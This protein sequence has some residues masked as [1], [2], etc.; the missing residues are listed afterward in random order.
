MSVPRRFNRP[1]G[2][3][4]ID[5]LIEDDA[6]ISLYFN[7]VEV[8]EVI[9][10][11]K[12]SFL[13][14]G[15][16][17]LKPQTEIKFE[18]TN[19]NTGAVIY[20][21]PVP[22][23]LEGTSRRVSIEVYEDADLFGDATLTVVGELDPSQTDVPV[24]FQGV[25]NVRYT[26]KIYV[27][28]AG[29]NTQPI[30]FYNQPRMVVGEI[31]KP[32]I[33]TTTPSG[34]AQQTGN[35]TGEPTPE[36][37]GKTTNTKEIEE[38]GSFLKTEKNKFST[39]LFGGGGNNSFVRKGR[40]RARRS[41]PETDK[42]TITKKDG[43]DFDAKLIGGELTIKNPQVDTSKFELQDFHEVP[44]TFKADI[45]NVKNTGTLVPSKPFTIIDTRFDED[46]PER[47]VIV[48]LAESGFE[49]TASFSPLPTQSI[50]TVNFRSYADIRLSKL[51]TFSGDIDRV[52]VYA[53]NKD[54]F[55]DFEVVS[56]Q[57]I[58]S[59]ELLFNVFGA[60]NQRI[61]YFFNQDH[62][63]LYWTSG[64]NTS[65]TQDSEYILN[66]VEV[67]GSNIGIDERLLFQQT[68]SL[69][70]NYLKDVD[71]EITANVLG[72]TGPKTNIDNSISDQGLAAIFISG[73]GFEVNHDYGDSL[74]F[75][76]TNINNQPGFLRVTDGSIQDFGLINESFSPV[77][78]GTGIIQFVVFSGRFYIS[79]V[80]I[81]PATDT[82]FSPNFIQ[83]IAPVPPLTQ[84]RPDD[85]EFLAEFY[86]VN[87]NIAETIAFASASTFEGGNSYIL[88][89]DNVLSGSMFIGSSIGGGIEMAGVSSGFIRSIGY[90]GF[91]SASAYPSQGPGFL[92]FSGSV[93]SS[94]T[95]DYT[96]GGVGLELVGHSGSYFRFRTEPAEL[97][98]RTDAFFIGNENIQFI[99]GS[100][101]N[102]EISSS[103]FHLDPK[104]DLLKIGADAIIDADLSVNNI[105]S[106]AGSNI[107]T[108]LAA[109]TSDGFAKFVSASIGAF[110]LNNDSLFSGPNDRPNFFIS[111]SASGTDYFISSSNFQVRAT[112]EVSASSLQLDGGSV[113]G[114]DV[115]DDTVSVGDI[116]KLKD[117]GEITG[118]AVLL[119][120][121]SLSQYLQFIDNT[122]T[123]RG[124]ITVDQ[125]LTPATIAGSP[126]TVLN[127]SSSITADGL[128][129]FKSGSIAGWKIFG[130]KLSGSNATLDADGAAL[131]KSDQGPGTDSGAAF[132][133]LRDEY[134]IDFTPEGGGSSGY[135]IKMGPN[136]GVDKDGILFA[137]GAT[138][139]GSISASAGLIGGFTIGSSSLFSSDLFISGSPL[140]GGV[141]DPRYMFISTSKFNVKQNGD[142]T[143]SN[144]KFSGGEIAGWTINETN[145]TSPDTGIRLNANGD[146][147]EISINS[148]TFANEGIQLGY[149]GGNPRFYA[150]DGAQNFLRYDTSNGVSIKTLKFELDTTALELSSTHASMSLGT[151]GEVLIRG[152]SNS[153]FI[154]LQ[155]S[156]ALVD[157]SYGE[158]GVF[159]GVA[160]GST[161]L[162][163][164]VGTGGH[165]KFNGSSID[166]STDTAV[167]SGSNIQIVS[168]TFLL[169]SISDGNFI[170]GSNGNM[171]IESNNF[172]LSASNIDISSTHASMSVGTTND[173]GHAIKLDGAQGKILVG[174]QSNK[175]I[176]ILGNHAK[177][178]IATGKSSV[179]DTTE[180]FWFANNNAN[181]EFHVGDSNNFIKMQ[182]ALLE[183]TTTNFKLDTST[184]DVDT[185]GGGSIALGT[186]PNTS[187]AGTNKGIFMSGSGDFLLFGN[188]SN[189]F[190]F[191]ST[192][193]SIELKTDTFDLDASTL[194]MKSDSTGSIALGASPP[195]AFDSG[196]GFFVD[197]GGNLLV[198][199]SSGN[200]VQY[201]ATSGTIT[202]K[203][204]TFFLDASTIVIDSSVNSGKIALGPTPPTAYN[205]GNGFYVDGTGKLLIGSGSGN[206]VQF[207]G[208]NIDIVAEAF[209]IGNSNAQFISGSNN[210]IE[211]S[212]SLFHLDPANDALIIGADA[213]INADLTV[214]NLRT[215][216][217][218]GGTA[219]TTLNASSSITS[220]GFA[221]FVSAS[222]GGFDVDDSTITSTDDSLILR[223]SGQISGSAVLL[224]DKS[225]GQ[226]LQFVDSTLTVQ[227]D[228]TANNI[229]TPSSIGGVASTDLNA[230]SSI[231]SQGFA[232]F[233]SAS[234]GGF[235][236]DSSQINSSNDNLVLKSN[237]QITGSDVLFNGG[238]VGGWTITA[239]QLEANNI[240]INAASGYIE[241]GDLNNV[242]DIGDSS[243]GFFANKDGEVLIK[244]GTSA[245]KNYMQFKN[246]TLD[247][248]TDTANISGSS[249]TLETPKFF[250]GKQNFQFVSG[251]NGN[252]EISSSNFHLDNT[253][254]VIMSGNITATTGEIGGFT[255]DSDEIKSAANI[256]LNSSTK[257]LTINDATFGNQGI[258][259][260][261][262]SGTPRMY[263]GDGSSEFFKFDGTNID[264][265][266][267]K[268]T[269]SGSEITL[270]SPDFFLGDTNNFISGSGG[271]LKIFSTGDTTLSGSSV[272]LATPK[273]FMGATGSAYVSGSDGNI[274]ISSSKFFLKSDGTLN[275]GAGNLTTTTDGDVTMT[276]T[277]TANAGTIG[278]FTIDADEIKSGTNI[279]LNSA[280]KALT[281]NDATFGNQGIQL[282]YNSGTP[283]FYVGDGSNRHVK[284]D[285]T[286]VDIKT[287]TFLLDTT[288][289][290]IDSSTARIEVSDGS[291]TRVRI[292]EVDSTS[293][294]HFGL[295]IFDGT[296]TAAS[297]EI[298]HLSD[299]KNQIASWSLS[300]NQI[301][302]QNLVIDSAG[303]I[304]TSDFASG[305]QG[306]RITSANNGEAEFEKVT[307]RGT[308]ATTVFEKETVNAVGGQL[309]VANSTIISQSAQL[310]A[311][312]TTMS[313]AN[314][315]GFV[316]D[317]IISAKK[318]SDTGFSTEYMLIESA[319]RD[320]PSSDKNFAGKLFVVRGYSGSSPQDS[321]SLGD[322]AG[323]ATTY[324]NGQ[325]IV[326]T[327]KIGTGFIRLN[328]NPNDQTTP[329]IDIV[330]RTGSAIYDVS[331][332]ARLGD[333]SGLS[334]GL[335]YGE[336][337]PGFGLF[338]ENVFLSGAITAQT[339]SIEGILH[340]RTDLNNQIKIGTN[341]E[342]SLDGIYIND[343]NF[344]YT[345]GH[346][347]TGFD[348][349]NFIHQSGSKLEIKS[350]DI[351]F[352][353]SNFLLEADG[354]SGQFYLGTITSDSDTSG[355]GVF[356][357]SGGHF[358]VIGNA[359]NQLIVDGGS[360][361]MKS[362]TFDL[363]TSTIHI[364]SSQGGAIAMG[365][366]IPTQLDD[367][368]IFL[369]GSG[370]FNLQGDS[371]NFLRRD[372]NVLT[373][374]AEVFDLDSSTLVMNSAANSGKIA[375]GSTPPTSVAYTANA[376]F[377]VD[378]T[379][380]FLVRADASN[381]IKVYSNTLQL[382][383]ET[384]D[385]DAGTLIIDSAAN[386]GT[387]SLGSTPN[388]SVAGTNTGFYVDGGGDVLLRADADNFIKMNIGSSPVLDMKA[389]TFF[390]GGSAQF[391]S[392]SNGK[393]EVS[394]SNFHLQPDGDTIMQGKITATSGQI[395]GLNIASD[396]IFVGT[397]N[398]NNSDTAFYV[399]DDG[400]FSLKDKLSWD[401]S[402]LSIEGSIT[403]TGG[404]GFASPDAVSGSFAT[405]EAV[406]GSV[407]TLSGSVATD[408]GG[409][410]QGSQ[411]MAT[412][413]VLDSAGMTLKNQSG[414]TLAEYGTTI[415]LRGNGSTDDRLDIDS[416]GIDIFEGGQLRAI[417]GQ[418]T[419]L[420]SGGAAVTTTSTDDC[421]RIADGTVSIFQDTNNKAVV[422]SSGLVVTQGG[423]DV[424]SFG[425]DTVITGGTITIRSS[426]NNND[427]VV[428][429]QD[430][431]KVF[432]NNTDVASF[433]AITRIGDKSNEHISMSSAG[434]TVKDGTTQRAVFAAT[435]VIGSSTDKVTISDSGITIRENNAD[436]ITM[437]EGVVTIGSSTDKVTINGTSGITIRENNVDAISLSSGAITIRAANNDYIELDGTSIDIFR[438]NVSV[439]NLTDSA[440]TLGGTSNEHIIVNTDGL[441][442]KDGGTVR[443][444]FT[445]AG[446][447][448]GN[449]SDAHVSASTFNVSIIQDANHKAVIDASGMTVTEGGNQVAQFAAT[450]V[451]GSSTDKVTIS[452]SGITIRENNADSITLSNGTV[453][454]RAANND[455]LEI[456]GTSIDIFRNNV[457]VVNLTD[458]AFTLGGTSNEHIIVDTD[459]LT[460]K[461]GGTVR[462]QFK[463]TGATIGNT[464]DAHISASTFDISIIQD[465]NHKA[466]IDASGMTVT[467]GG[468]Q[469]AQF[470]ATTVIGS[471]TDKVTISDSGGIVIRENNADSITLNNGAVEIRAANNDYLEIDGTSI[472]IFRNNV[473]VVNLTDSAFT[474]GGT[475]NEHIIVDTD[476]LTIKD[477]GTIR[478]KFV[479][480]GAT[481]GVTTN[482]HISASTTDISIIKDGNN[483]AVVS[484]D[485]MK[486]TQGGTEVAD[487][488]STVVIG[489]VGASKSNVQ[490]TS[491]AINLRNNLTNKMVL[492]ADGSITIGDD[493][494]VDS[495]GNASFGG[496]LTIGG[497]V[498][499]SA[500]L[501]GDISGSNNATSASLAGI[502][503]G[504]TE[505]SQSMATQVVLDS[506]GMTLKNAG[507]TTLASYGT[508][509]S[510]R[511][512]GSTDDRLD[513][514]AD[515]VEI[516]EGGQLRTIIGQ[517]TVLG[518]GGAAVTTTSTDDCIRIA[519]G[520]VSIFQDD[521]NKAII[522][523][524]GL[525]ITQGGNEVGA[526]GANPVITGGTVTIRSHDNNDDKIIIAQDSFKIFDNGTKVGHFGAITAIGDTDNEHI[527]MSSNGLTLKDGGT[528]IGSFKATGATIGNT[529]NA[530]VSASTLDVSVIKDSNNKAVVSSDGL[531][532]TQN[533]G[534]R[535]IFGA[536]SVIGSSGAAV[537][538]TSTDDCIRIS[539][540]EVNIFQDSN[541]LAKLSSTGL[542]VTQSG[543]GVANFA[544]TTTIGNTSTEHIEIT[545]T[546]LK[547]KDGGTTRVTMDSGGVDIGS[548]FT[549]DTNGNVSMTG[550]ITAEAGSIGQWSILKSSGELL[551]AG[552]TGNAVHSASFSAGDSAQFLLRAT[553]EVDIPL[554]ANPNDRQ[555]NPRQ[556]ILQKLDQ[557]IKSIASSKYYPDANG[558]GGS[559]SKYSGEELSLG[560]VGS[561]FNSLID[562]HTPVIGDQAGYRKLWRYRDAFDDDVH[563]MWQMLISSGSETN[564]ITGQRDP[565]R[566]CTLSLITNQY[567]H[568][569]VNY[570]GTGTIREIIRIGGMKGSFLEDSKVPNNVKRFGVMAPTGSFGYLH[571][572]SS[573]AQGGTGES[574]FHVNSDGIQVTVDGDYDFLFKDGGE[575]HADADILAFS[576]TTS[577]ISLKDNIQTI[578]GSLNKVMNLR[579]V[580]YVWNKGGRKGQKDLGVVAQ[581]VEKVLPE[582]VREKRLPL[583]DSSDKTY[584]T[585]DYE[586]ITAVLIEGM[587]EQQEQIDDLR[588]EVEELKD[589]SSK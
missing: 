421:I 455:Y 306:W 526:F 277:I 113:G 93:L 150:G 416:D 514:D 177:A 247:I 107:N 236:V 527:S 496:T 414:T 585:V 262:N 117:T 56:D 172:E 411:S 403:I 439:V 502:T 444:K 448:I 482:A 215:P 426:A 42:F 492:G 377:Y 428:L 209:F 551:S 546:S 153:P 249:I 587:K 573:T 213:T 51:R 41:S 335:L 245:N 66:S 203:S 104:N 133:Q 356:M 232:T 192:G 221:R 334:S 584:K 449:T 420:G 110:K 222:I 465:S 1:Q 491:G 97:D 168:P 401:G 581:E 25:Y 528:T 355:Q 166:I 255:I 94:I 582:I 68:G 332:K 504:L 62:V 252:I 419:V 555:P 8:P 3:A 370:E 122:L 481:L 485:G 366:T 466:V 313:V 319:S 431:F 155:P 121:K 554:S 529:S 135:Y 228:I 521:S 577:D 457:S 494:S 522:D 363:L 295:V 69:P 12:S 58:E 375:L 54:A 258:Q 557:G 22:N 251:S 26:R 558:V 130:S 394:S 372:D 473:S 364:S 440:F 563:E 384:F 407:D 243:V 297:D 520:T 278:G 371:N 436:T 505:G 179:S 182:S 530:H 391:L 388:T 330:E 434:M 385:L 85:Y 538:T 460:I 389:E 516:F 405:G 471:S 572:S 129:T 36:E 81:T 212:S 342:N 429:T 35:V 566:G 559:L 50:S 365:S 105:F 311:T 124:D 513:I 259:L 467:E 382:K 237:G 523:S 571:L 112:G 468:N 233:K 29:V 23:Y 579:G 493:F 276:G 32:Y 406:S 92:M 509:V 399:E 398:H 253:G 453:E 132:P 338:T 290:D 543:A 280:N 88:G 33:T 6:P 294:S 588:R 386:N 82:G 180:G 300:P 152:N 422:N 73:S 75:Q 40:R 352:Q 39:K 463:S 317:E 170:S 148:H 312:A 326:S 302:S 570:A 418:T 373:I 200:R 125:I 244:A 296:G 488:G 145:L 423:T 57:Q 43:A 242:N 139:Q 176:E 173:G 336:T 116:L 308:L 531:A 344:W 402:N 578:S 424:G 400:K 78:D 24:E 380:D 31:V 230:S 270:K 285:G 341:V 361:T 169:G 510:L 484:S 304:Q 561:V 339:G 28:S 320:E 156:V 217:T 340:V 569:G 157:K 358:R 240:K 324:E 540:G 376:G 315:A 512:N 309:Y 48:P 208:S 71:Y 146:N 446:A 202:L 438:N 292:G 246:G 111:G 548:N 487:F 274:E 126:S 443:G 80:S 223:S 459:G 144:A 469:V 260:E 537:T 345:N 544:G 193:N 479:A 489:E 190:K 307:V 318:I 464:S 174:S 2:L 231:D 387:I 256:A 207:D 211:I 552:T 589:G 360:L 321:G 106:P 519:N 159:L 161:P 562:G 109:I 63:N 128:A 550:E 397:G 154:S 549:V 286:D 322:S 263:V 298:V 10:Q 456:D 201:N 186:T 565:F 119:G 98:I 137:S 87:N 500:Q 27:S 560:A 271:S 346:F 508:T 47:E 165:L 199:S 72:F 533:S 76:L 241:A 257:A 204:Q 328:A 18:I 162:F 84:E 327:G 430:S 273:F 5:V 580:E 461:D 279:S 17:L 362:D 427:K 354:S 511:G 501:A 52:K 184:F 283:R 34:S 350:E 359:T 575:F 268:A 291:A 37:L 568:Q 545:S 250:L 4:N 224:G 310:S 225:S 229:R 381:F 474:L 90:K 185:A 333:L 100:D 61:G 316:E 495:D 450:S 120:D 507:G 442:I 183:I 433:G 524:S 534:V 86:D 64:S 413:V 205:S 445:A 532:V 264:I 89:D 368:G 470:A 483:K 248:R 30:L 140:E 67:S 393:L 451:I 472:D 127:A 490:I 74:G 115:S 379:G 123:V 91:S 435:S 189:F 266:T 210:N 282:E 367:N 95:D 77:R 101:A 506:D 536:T 542:E 187:I 462:G 60:G 83:V 331:L 38:P 197:G 131:Y 163:S 20:T 175:R 206:H 348:G 234:I 191:D 288:N 441:T 583:M 284:F 417:F 227:G 70:I 349:D 415:S 239:N 425:S 65:V 114:L 195:A 21:E 475:S 353:G 343:N 188:S 437:A 410:T 226:F 103:L 447:T 59:P 409:L 134:Y 147:A 476:G 299:A 498:S 432:D 383:S 305:V 235:V 369:S 181:P 53:R 586:R 149:N 220:E 301:T 325:V 142:V 214:N 196:T 216:A 564:N 337:N 480:G 374:K 357:D 454:I 576:T 392:G 567:V 272:T 55:G 497:L 19:D 314:V 269:I 254:D 478:G 160:G 219:S 503:D 525:T 408:V 15:S 351:D 287:D 515:G 198:G 553:N 96:S 404:S 267:Q 194:V 539:N 535:A 452:D 303:I 164:A 541:N 289:L 167:I 108:A 390:L 7:V 16:N 238:V 395:A 293:A 102:I 11:G 486:I 151:S 136:F 518:S 13:I 477:G 49:F 99:S 261:Y 275:I 396:K 517:T 378:G 458:S 158:V 574:T 281:I 79:D 171:S 45:E 44:T 138:F 141:D 46:S 265:R 143:G 118:S 218:I 329:Y 556:E 347:K 547:L 178:Y 9:T 14:G 499:G 323:S 412:Q